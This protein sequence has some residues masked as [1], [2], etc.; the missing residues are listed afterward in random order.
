MNITLRQLVYLRE[1]ARSR[2]FTEAANRLHTSQS[3]L[4]TAIRALEELLGVRLI[5][6]STK[7]FE[8]T[9]AGK[10]FLAVSERVLNDL[11]A[12]VES[13]SAINRLERG[14]L[15]IGAPALHAATYLP[16]IIGAF[17]RK[18]PALELRLHEVPI[19]ELSNMLRSR[20]IEIAIGSFRHAGSE[21]ITKPLFE[22]NL[23]VLAHRDV[24]LP[25]PCT[26]R[27]LLKVPMVSIVKTSSVGQLIE[28]TAWDTIQ[29][30]YEPLLE[31]ASWMSVVA[32][33]ESLRAASIVPM[34]V[35]LQGQLGARK[36]TLQILQL[37]RPVVRRAIS[38]A[39][40]ATH[41][42]TPTAQAFLEH[43]DT[44]AE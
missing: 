6:R 44:Q 35:A 39:Y 5:D 40:L 36:D 11:D 34:K 4:S 12:A 32:F 27:S 42:L 24:Q 30:R 17:H 37:H 23:V 33:T 14:T 31:V 20:D 16:D 13:T 9:A 43:L 29:Q 41:G 1:I 22:D 25:D 10:S 38:V 26:W 28:E 8:L 3:N 18:Y 21:F 15:T 7:H 2:S 19:R